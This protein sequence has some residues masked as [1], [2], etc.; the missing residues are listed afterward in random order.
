MSKYGPLS[1]N[2]C[3]YLGGPRFKSWP[4]DW[5]SYLRVSKVFFCPSVQCPKSGHT[6][7]LP[8][9]C[10]VITQSPSY[11]WMLYSAHE[12]AICCNPH[13]SS[14]WYSRITKQ[15]GYTK[16]KPFLLVFSCVRVHLFMIYQV[17]SVSC[18]TV[19]QWI[20]TNCCFMSDSLHCWQHWGLNINKYK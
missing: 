9:H 5:L 1:T 15:L 18:K 11:H 13:N 10:Q 19:Y 4:T 8:H 7:C 20:M 2:A 3:L 12:T 17:L 14:N 16:K 6:H